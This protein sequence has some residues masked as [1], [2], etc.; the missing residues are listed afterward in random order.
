MKVK[1]SRCR[2]FTHSL[3]PKGGWYGA[4]DPR[5]EGEAIGG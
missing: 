3:A 5:W 2:I 1:C 4:A